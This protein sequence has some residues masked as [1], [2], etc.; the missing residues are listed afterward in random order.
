MT[1]SNS[2][3]FEYLQEKIKDSFA[4]A[5]NPAIL[6]ACSN[7]FRVAMQDVRYSSSL[8]GSMTTLGTVDELNGSARVGELA[9]VNMAGLASISNF[10]LEPRTVALIHWTAELVDKII[11]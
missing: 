2:H 7:I 3:R 8:R 10:S 5:T 4:S 11:E 1:D 9:E 6:V